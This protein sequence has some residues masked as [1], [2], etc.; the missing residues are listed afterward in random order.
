MLFDLKNKAVY[1]SKLVESI[2][3][4]RLSCGGHGFSAYARF[5]D[6]FSEYSPFPTYE[7]ENTVLH[8]QAARHLVKA[9]KKCLRGDKVS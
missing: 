1:T 5:T 2:E 9:L 3:K 4:I 6:L 8:L 7:G